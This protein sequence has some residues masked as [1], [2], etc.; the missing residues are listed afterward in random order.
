[1]SDRT[2]SWDIYSMNPDGSD[3]LQLTDLP[4]VD[5]LATASPDGSNIAFLTDR[6]G[7]WS[8]Y[9]MRSD[10]GSVRKLIDLPGNFGR[11]DYDWFQERLSWGR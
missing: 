7:V 8:L 4:G 6:D 5:G 9:V 10:G 1:M 2:G 3:L 11:G